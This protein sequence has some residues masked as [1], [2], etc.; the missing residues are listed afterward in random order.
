MRRETRDK[1]I[2]ALQGGEE[3][4]EEHSPMTCGED[5]ET[6]ERCPVSTCGS[7]ADLYLTSIT[8]RLITQIKEGK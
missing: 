8:R 1:V 7:D 4:S 2:K 3:G 5:I 6:S